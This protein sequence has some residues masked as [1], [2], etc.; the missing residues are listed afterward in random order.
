MSPEYKKS[1]RGELELRDY[2]DNKIIE[3]ISPKFNRCVIFIT[4]S[5]SYH[6]HPKPLNSPKNLARRSL[7]LY[8]FQ[9][10]KKSSF[11]TD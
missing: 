2:K 1:W 7:A 3:S 9:V 5:K 6:G 11:K 4:D 8:Y 10:S